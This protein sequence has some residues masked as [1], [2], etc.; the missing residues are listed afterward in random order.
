MRSRKDCGGVYVGRAAGVASC[1][2][3]VTCTAT[4]SVPR[5]APTRAPVRYEGACDSRAGRA[6]NADEEFGAFKQQPP[7]ATPGGVTAQA[8]HPTAA[9]EGSVSVGVGAR[10]A[11][12]EEA[13]AVGIA[14]QVV[15]NEL[16]KAASSK[17]ITR[18]WPYHC[19]TPRRIAFAAEIEITA[20]AKSNI[21]KHY[22]SSSINYPPVD[23]LLIDPLVAIE[24]GKG[25][26]SSRSSSSTTSAFIE[27]K[28]SQVRQFRDDVVES[29]V[30][31]YKQKHQSNPQNKQQRQRELPD[32]QSV[33]DDFYKVFK[34]RQLEF[35]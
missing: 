30:Q 29:K 24:S 9:P 1:I 27:W 2:V 4:R 17:P 8:G 25:G 32:M 31:P 12:A 7:R 10:S 18:A 3:S 35:C 6:M 20:K 33:P 15:E 28:L 13:S 16:A 14:E 21:D 26:A 19:T 23:P 5:R 11:A 22:C 34:R